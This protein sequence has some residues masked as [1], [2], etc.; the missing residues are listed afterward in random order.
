MRDEKIIKAE[1]G[2]TLYVATAESHRRVM[3]M[4]EHDSDGGETYVFLTKKQNK[5]LRKALK[6]AAKVAGR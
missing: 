1:H 4:A 3:L 2:D 5:K 6:R